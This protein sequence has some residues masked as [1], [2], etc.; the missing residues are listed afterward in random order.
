MMTHHDIWRGI[1]LLAESRGLSASGLARKA[2]LDPTTFNRS[3]RLTAAGKERW[4]ST[5]SIATGEYPVSRPLYF[6]VKKA[7]I[8]V[9]PGLKEYAEFF[10]SDPVAGPAGP[11]ASYG[12]VSD[13]ELATVQKTVMEENTMQ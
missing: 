13:P 3:K 8:G 2:G 1:D 6:Y 11:L 9:I 7:H 10:V 12:L 5:E 4:P